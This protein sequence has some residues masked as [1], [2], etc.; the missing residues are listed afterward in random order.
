MNLCYLQTLTGF[1]DKAQEAYYIGTDKRQYRKV[2]V[3]EYIQAVIID[4]GAG[5]N[6]DYLEIPD[7]VLYIED[8]EGGLDVDQGYL[9]SSGNRNYSAT[10]EGVLT[11]KDQTSYLAIPHKMEKLTVPETVT[12]VSLTADN[13]LS[14]LYLE[15]RT[16][17]LMPEISYQNL[18]GC[19]TIID[20][21][22]LNAFLEQNYKAAGGK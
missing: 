9:V 21:N 7:T 20:D 18:H 5:L 13:N 6:T 22:L 17:D 4:A 19:K 2:S 3:P 11:N 8:T 15:A 1:T 12:K 14:E 10:K 16:L